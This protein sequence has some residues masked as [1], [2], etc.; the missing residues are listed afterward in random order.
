M[1]FCAVQGSEA[2]DSGRTTIR[3]LTSQ[4]EVL[5]RNAGET[6]DGS[7]GERSFLRASTCRVS[8]PLRCRRGDGWWTD[9]FGDEIA[10]RGSW[11]DS[12]IACRKQWPIADHGT[13]WRLASLFQSTHPATLGSVLVNYSGTSKSLACPGLISVP[14]TVTRHSFLHYLP[15]PTRIR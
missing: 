2:S 5:R 7:N 6:L 8:T 12:T 15:L 13:Q 11:I 9:G 3:R 1:R 14:R 10:I 4:M